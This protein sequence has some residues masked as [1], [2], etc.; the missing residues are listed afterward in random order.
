MPMFFKNRCIA[1]A[2]SGPDLPVTF[3]P[4]V[5]IGCIGDYLHP[6]SMKNKPIIG[7]GKMEIFIGG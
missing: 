3:A 1:V 4:R 5:F 7:A 6:G 2:G